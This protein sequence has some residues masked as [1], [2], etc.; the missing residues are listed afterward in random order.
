[1]PINRYAHIGIY[2]L[3]DIFVVYSISL[4]IHVYAL[5]S[6]S[7][8]HKE[9]VCDVRFLSIQC[10]SR[11]RICMFFHRVLCCT[12]SLL[13]AILDDG[14]A[15]KWQNMVSTTIGTC[16]QYLFSIY[17]VVFRRKHLNVFP[18]VPMLAGHHHGWQ[19]SYKLQLVVCTSSHVW[20]Q[21][22]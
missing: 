20:F 10:A 12:K 7:A 3:L 1:M 18:I 15:I 11:R 8:H 17:S 21:S 19:I 22:I 13:M 9:H 4:K 16:M 5:R 14:S 6:P 2:S